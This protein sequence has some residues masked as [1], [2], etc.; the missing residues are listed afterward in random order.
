MSLGV[1]SFIDL[2]QMPSRPGA[3]RYLSFFIW[4][5]SSSGLVGWIGSLGWDGNAW[6]RVL[7]TS[8]FVV[9]MN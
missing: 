1:R 9:S 4:F 5:F 8:L 3:L 6:V 2:L 7:L